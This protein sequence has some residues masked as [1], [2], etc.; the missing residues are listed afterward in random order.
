MQ[1]DPENFV[2]LALDTCDKQKSMIVKTQAAKLLEAICDNIDGAVSFVT[3]FCCQAISISLSK[4]PFDG[5][6][7]DFQAYQDSS[8]LKS[9]PELIA[10][11]CLVALTAISYILPRRNDLVPLF[12][13]V[14]AENIDHILSK[15]SIILRARMSLL[16][17][18]YADMLFERF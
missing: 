4:H 13:K 9:N 11:T 12:E 6:S 10:E 5:I 15:D 3:L 8:F 18:Y 17:G 16:L 14:L 1:K 2:H 7:H